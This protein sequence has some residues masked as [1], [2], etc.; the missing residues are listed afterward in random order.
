MNDR[1]RSNY[2]FQ[3]IAWVIVYNLFGIPLYFMLQNFPEKMAEQQMDSGFW[4]SIAMNN[5]CGIL[6]GLMVGSIDLL[7]QRILKSKHSFQKMLLVKSSIYSLTFITFALLTALF[8]QA[9]QKDLDLAAAIHEIQKSFA[10]NI[11]FAYILLNI[12]SSIIISFIIQL[13]DLAGREKLFPLLA[14][15]YYAPRE[16]QRVFMFLDLRSSTTIAEQLGH[17]LFSQLIQDCFYDLNRIIGRYKAIIYQYAGDEAILTW[18]QK[19]GLKNLN[20]LRVFYAYQKALEERSDHYLEKYGIRPEFKAGVN[21]GDVMVAEI[22]EVKKEIAYHGDV[23]NTAARIQGLC[24]Q[25]GQN[26]L[27]SEFLEKRLDSNRAFSRQCLGEMALKGKNKP[28][29]VYGIEGFSLN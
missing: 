4:A 8:W 21:I 29:K 15:R 22:G 12:M 24:N 11:I 6:M 23:L 1:T 3:I 26:L 16:E 13:S 20:C 2:Q 19:D 5:A 10:S 7:I 27:I 25:Y 28:V 9:T 14:G 17:V 18:Q